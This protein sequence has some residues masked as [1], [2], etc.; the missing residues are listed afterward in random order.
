VLAALALSFLPPDARY[1]GDQALSG[2]NIPIHVYHSEAMAR[3]FSP[4]PAHVFTRNSP[5]PKTLWQTPSVTAPAP[6]GTVSW[7]CT[8]NTGTTVQSNTCGIFLGS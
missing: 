7:V 3:L 8:L 5:P 4:D 1:I 2:S 6:P